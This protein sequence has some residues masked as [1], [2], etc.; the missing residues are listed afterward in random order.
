MNTV[1]TTKKAA[2]IISTFSKRERSLYDCGIG[3][4]QQDMEHIVKC[5]R[6]ITVYDNV[7]PLKYREAIKAQTNLTF[8]AKYLLQCL[9]LYVYDNYETMSIEVKTISDK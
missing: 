3:Y 7:N 1:T 6:E 8:R 4:I 5:D 2:A 9:D